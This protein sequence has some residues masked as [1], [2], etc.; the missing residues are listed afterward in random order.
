MAELRKFGNEMVAVF[1]NGSLLLLTQKELSDL[2]EAIALIQNPGVEF[3]DTATMGCFGE[4][5]GVVRKEDD[6]ARH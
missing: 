2:V 6:N 1:I 5:P 4:G 3:V